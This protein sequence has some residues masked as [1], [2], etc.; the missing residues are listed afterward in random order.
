MW[1]QLEYFNPGLEKMKITCS[2]L[3]YKF[4]IKK[5]IRGRVQIEWNSIVEPDA[6]VIR[7]GSEWGEGGVVYGIFYSERNIHSQSYSEITVKT[8]LIFEIHKVF[9]S[10]FPKRSQKYI[11][12]GNGRRKNLCSLEI[13]WNTLSFLKELLKKKNKNLK[14]RPLFLVITR[15]PRKNT[16]NMDSLNPKT[17][18]HVQYLP[19][20]R[21]IL[22][23]FY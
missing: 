21:K 14:F 3:E 11:H 13:W 4:H 18:E 15:L 16:E 2:R 1:P 17:C 20:P 23:I 6:S 19:V 7:N 8:D 22:K 9:L 12:L 5:K 10:D